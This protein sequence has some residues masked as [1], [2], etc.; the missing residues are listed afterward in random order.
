MAVA[1]MALLPPLSM[2]TIDGGGGNG[3]NY[4]YD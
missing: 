1:A 2:T 4:G 3:H